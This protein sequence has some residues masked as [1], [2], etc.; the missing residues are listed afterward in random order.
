MEISINVD[1]P[2]KLD[3]ETLCE[4]ARAQKELSARGK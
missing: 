1:V 4:S 2:A 3:I